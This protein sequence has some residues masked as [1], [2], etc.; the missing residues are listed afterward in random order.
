MQRKKIVDRLPYLRALFRAASGPSVFSG[1]TVAAFF[2]FFWA[3][4]CVDMN[5]C[6]V[7]PSHAIEQTLV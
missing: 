3:G 2:F 6:R 7:L 1:F 4:A 5:Q